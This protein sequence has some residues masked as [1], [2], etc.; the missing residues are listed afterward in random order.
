M[1]ILFNVRKNKNVGDKTEFLLLLKKSHYAAVGFVY[2]FV[3]KMFLSHSHRME[4][5]EFL[6]AEKIAFINIHRC[7]L[8]VGDHAV[9]VS[10]DCW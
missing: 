1:F 7:L 10:T 5:T 8:N 4:P 2:K 6:H 3:E 9:D